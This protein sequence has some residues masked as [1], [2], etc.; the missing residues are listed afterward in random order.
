MCVQQIVQCLTHI[1]SARYME[2]GDGTYVA[3][4]FTS[5]LVTAA[6]R[7][8]PSQEN[9]GARKCALCVLVEEMLLGVRTLIQYLSEKHIS[10]ENVFPKNLIQ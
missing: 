1:Q 3:T 2:S 7:E 4:V 8:N 5:V 10:L 9:S 6:M